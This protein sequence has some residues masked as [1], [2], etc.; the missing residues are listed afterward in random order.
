MHECPQLWGKLRVT[1]NS[2][3]H[4]HPT[5]QTTPHKDGNTASVP[6]RRHRD[7]HDDVIKWKHFPRNWPFVRGIHRSPVNSPH[8][9]QWRG[10]L[11]FSLIFV[12]INDWVNS[13]E[14]GDLRRHLDRY[15]VSV[16]Y[17]SMYLQFYFRY[18]V[19]FLTQRS[20]NDLGVNNFTEYHA[21]IPYNIHNNTVNTVHRLL[22]C[23]KFNVPIAVLQCIWVAWVH[24]KYIKRTPH[25]QAAYGRVHF[26]LTCPFH[27]GTYQALTHARQMPLETTYSCCQFH[28]W[29][30]QCPG[31][32]SLQIASFVGTMPTYLHIRS[33]F[34]SVWKS[35]LW[36]STF[37][38]N[39]HI[40][41][42]WKK[43]VKITI[44]FI[45]TKAESLRRSKYPLHFH[46]TRNIFACLNDNVSL[47]YML[48]QNFQKSS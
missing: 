15:D 26:I 19:M 11:M 4:S 20:K 25:D 6:G 5:P 47:Q 48:K 30:H 35:Y 10:A 37:F 8:K 38:R 46:P 2:T 31:F 17:W 14:A 22:L 45:Q 36:E 21:I 32:V 43:I 9:G 18:D 28:T 24:M 39:N 1:G 40:F 13:R 41:S 27:S 29:W 42:L 3:R 12:W 16:M 7:S 23:T 33:I 44:L 34:S